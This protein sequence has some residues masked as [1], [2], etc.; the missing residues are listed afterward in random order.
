MLDNLLFKHRIEFERFTPTTEQNTFRMYSE[1]N[2]AIYICIYM[3]VGAY[4]AYS[5]VNTK[6]ST[7]EDL[8]EG[9]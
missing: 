5:R 6:Y 2:L 3:Y 4:M 7:V 1:L 9:Y 8:V